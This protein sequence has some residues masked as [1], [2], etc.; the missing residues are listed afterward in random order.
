MKLS[1]FRHSDWINQWD[2]RW[3]ILSFSYWGNFY[4]RRPFFKD[5][6]SYVTQTIILWREGK[7]SAYQRQSEKKFFGKK[8]EKIIEFDEDYVK[9]ICGDVKKT[10]KN[11][12]DY[13][14]QF[15][16]KDISF[17]QYAEFQ[18]L[19]IEDY[20]PLHIIVKVVVDF[21]K[22][23]LL[24]KYLPMLQEARVYAEPVFTRS[25]DFMHELA[26]LHSRKIG[27]SPELILC[28][29]KNEFDFYLKNDSNLPSENILK[30]RYKASAFFFNET[31]MIMVTG[32]DA[33]EVEENLR[34]KSE[35]GIIRGNTAYPGKIQGRVRVIFDPAKASG[36]QE[37]EILVTGMTRPEFLPFMKK[38]AGFVTD[39][40]GILCHAA[41]VARELKKP[42]VIGTLIA[43][44]ELHDGDLVEVDADNGIVKIIRP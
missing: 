23:E 38:A 10:T 19:L 6:D 34:E 40:G 9:K 7:S 44:K 25:E 16:G 8:V 22:P 29:F 21:L 15:I 13:V 26:K 33:H 12:L 4:C 28:S 11:F 1:D 41:I 32:N 42:C 20:Y 27:I 30:D 39:G 43:S 17:K 18:K 31:E 37:G 3:S 5:M 35:K 14:D 24:L 2:G 36:F